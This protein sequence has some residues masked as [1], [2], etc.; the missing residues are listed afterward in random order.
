MGSFRLAAVE[1]LLGSN[2]RRSTNSSRQEWLVSDVFIHLSKP[3]N[4]WK[5]KSISNIVN[6]TPFPIFK[7]YFW[8]KCRLSMKF[9][10]HYSRTIVIINIW[11][12][13]YWLKENCFWKSFCTFILQNM[14]YLHKQI[15]LWKKWS[16]FSKKI[17]FWQQCICKIFI[18]V[19][20]FFQHLLLEKWNL[21]SFEID[22][23]SVSILNFQK[24]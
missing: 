8:R 1:F 3:V 15:V 18:K 19:K 22:M 5:L 23:P 21:K 11:S 9:K 16:S 2:W 17:C 4:F 13:H 24:L 20:L 6:M 12:L 10:I 7:Q 14:C